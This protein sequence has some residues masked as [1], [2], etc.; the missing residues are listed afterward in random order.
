MDLLDNIEFLSIISFFVL[1]TTLL[2]GFR[3]FGGLPARNGI[4]GSFTCIHVILQF[5]RKLGF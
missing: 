4:F 3:V 1:K 5:L 2:R